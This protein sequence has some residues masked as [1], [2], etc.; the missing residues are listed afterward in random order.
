MSNE[1]NRKNF[2]K[3]E[4]NFVCDNCQKNVEPLGKSCRNHC[5]VCLYSK[6]VDEFTP[7]DRKSI[8]QEKMEPVAL[9]REGEELIVVHKCQKCNKTI[10]NK[11]APD[12]DRKKLFSL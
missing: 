6:H 7:G 5:P 9:E 10:R 8:C 3:R 4:E 11:S 1:Q 2:I 12:D